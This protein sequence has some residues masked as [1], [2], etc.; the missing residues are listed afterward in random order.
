MRNRLPISLIAIFICLFGPDTF[1]AEG[2]TSGQFVLSPTGGAQYTIPIWAPPGPRGMQPNISLVYDSQAGIGPLGI[3]WSMSGLG[4]ITRCNLTV[5]QDTTPASVALVT[6]DG[7]CINGSRLRL[8]SG[9]YGTAGSVYQTEIAD[10]SQITAVGTAG[11]GPASFTVQAR[12]GLTYY[13]G[14]TD[15]NGNGVN[16]EVL[17][18][19]SST[20]LTWLLSKVVDRAGN[21]YVINYTALTGTAV[22]NDILWTPVSAGASTYT[23]KMLFNYTTNVPQSSINE[24]VAGT[25]VSNTD[26]LSSIEIFVGSTVVKDYFL[27]YQASPLTGREELISVKECAD[28]GGASCLLPTSISYQ[29]GAPGISTTPNSALSSSGGQLTTRYDLNGDGYPDLVYAGTTTMYVAFG[30]ATGYST[31]VN[32]G[33]PIANVLI[34]RLTE[35]SQDGILA[36]NAGTWWSYTWNGSSFVGT[37]T[38][39]AYDTASTGYQLADINGDGL[40]DLV[41]LNTV[42]SSFTKQYTETLYTQLN[43]SSGSTVSFGSTKYVSYS[44]IVSVSAQLLT[45]DMQYGKL[46]RYDFNGDGRDDLVLKTITG[47]SPNYVLKTYELLSSGTTFTASLIASAANGSYSPV[48]FTNWNDDKCTDFVSSNVLYVSGCNGTA[49]LSYALTGTILVA[50]DWDGDGRTDIL[51]QNGTTI[52]VYLSKAT[53]TPTMTTTTFPYNSSCQYVWMDANADGLDDLGCQNGAVTY[54]LHNGTSDLATEFADGYGNSASPTY[55]PISESNYTAYPSSSLQP[56]FPDIVYIGPLYVVSEVV[57]SDPS[58]AGNTYNQTF[59]YYAAWTNVQGRGF[60]GFQTIYT[61]DTRNAGPPSISRYQYFEQ[62]FPWTWMKYTDLITTPVFYPTYTVGTPNTLAQATLSTTTN[63][64]RFFPYFTN[65]TTTQKEVGGSENGDAITTTSTNYTYDAYGN[66]LTVD[67]TVTDNDPNSP[68]TGKTWTTNTTNT[69]DISVNQ[70]TDLAAWC[71][72]MLDET[73]VAYSSTLSGSTSVTRTKTFTPDTPANCRI[74][75]IITEPSGAYKVTESLVYDNSSG[76]TAFGNLISDTVAG[77]TT[78]PGNTVPSSPASRLT[79]LNW[80]TTGQFLNTLTDPSGATTTWTYS[81]NQALTFGVPDTKVDANALTTKYY[82]DAFGRKNRQIRPDGTSTTWTW[83]ACTSN[84]GNSVYQVAQT[85]YQTNGTTAIR[86]DTTS[87]D[88]VDRVTQTTGPTVTGAT[89]TVQTLYNSLGLV[90]EQSMPFLTGGTAYQQSFGYDVLNRLIE[91]ERPISASGGQ[92]YC[93][94]ASPPGSGCQGTSYT[95]AGRKLTITDPL[96]NTKTTVTDVNGWLRQTTDALGFYVTKAYD[97]AGSLVG[98]TDSVGN[99]LLKNV[100]VVYGIKPFVTAATDA[101]RGAWIYTVDSLGERL[102]W[103]DAKGQSFSMT[104]DALSRPLTRAEPDLYTQWTWGSTPASFNVG[105]LIAECTGSAGACSSSTG[106][107]ETRTF[108]SYGRPYQQSITQGGNPGFDPGGVFLITREYSTQDG[109][110]STLIYPTSTSSTALTLQYTYQYGLLNSVVDSTDTTAICGTTCTLWTASAM[111][112][113]GQ[114][115]Q[116]TLGNG[117]V[118]NRTYDPVTSWLTAAT[119]G[120]G[121]GAALLNQSYLQD[122][123]GNVTQRENNNTPGLYENFYYDGDN[124]LCDVVLNGTATRC[125]T[126]SMIYDGGNAGPG[127]ITTQTGVGTYAYPAAG[128]P[129]PH[130]VTSLTGTFNG[131]VNPIFSYDA[132][133]NMTSR[134]GSTVSWFSNNYPATISASDATGSEEV[135]FTYGPDRQRWKQTYTL[136]GATETT[137]YIGGL[138]DLVFNGITNFRHYIYAGSEPVAVYIRTNSIPT[139][140]NYMLEDHQGGVSAITSSVG[141]T[142]VNESFSS[143]GT[144]RNPNTWSGAPATADLNTIAGLSRQGYTF[145]TWLGQSMGLNH[146]NGR[147]QDAILGRFLSSDPHIP[148]P[149]NAQS[150]NRYSYVNNN[151]LTFTDPTGFYCGGPLAV[152]GLGLGDD[153][154]G[155]LGDDPDQLPEVQVNAPCL[156]PEVYNIPSPQISTPPPLMTGAVPR[157]PKITQQ[158]A[159]SAQ[160]N[161][162]L[163]PPLDTS[164]NRPYDPSDPSTHLYSVATPAGFLSADQQQQLLDLWRNGPNAAPG[165]AP[166][167]PDNTNVLLA[168]LPGTPNT[169]W[170]YLTPVSSGLGWV[171]VTQPGHYFYSGTVTNTVQTLGPVTYLSTVGTGDTSR[172]LQNDVFGSAFFQASQ[173]EAIAALYGA[174][175]VRIG[176]AGGC[177]GNH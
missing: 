28:S 35:G 71:L 21:N 58:S 98:V 93:N 129:Q 7:Y 50:L 47:T 74:T 25:L 103:T 160:S 123:N 118:I 111:N 119:A 44:T 97:S 157:F 34:G 52:G 177:N 5:A 33:I 171:N 135:Q 126:P 106:Y 130:A 141:G 49:A 46:R 36:N 108:D 158:S 91:S 166:N 109:R 75:A 76:G 155:D 68:Y 146:M 56:T 31:P 169:N 140:M 125:T 73:Q 144:R 164:S 61:Y 116:E 117:V 162:C 23:Y 165:I 59:H 41:D 152:P 99:S 43:T 89:A 110:L 72:N 8:T 83:S 149:T 100:A 113:F 137:Y 80:G 88:P 10:F 22:P 85:A 174:P 9:T 53:G 143:F 128:Q 153:L 163:A 64:E 4:A 127:N 161:P 176:S 150:Y 95:Y 132:N 57:F 96:G 69:T 2:R 82:Y 62:Q 17:A 145:Q 138:I 48:F 112:G 168:N 38:G 18:N 13:Y 26:L 78:A 65:V 29:G 151:P 122:E 45:P 60:E 94:P 30:S 54:Y 172:W 15:T 167:T 6:G 70:S 156:P 107:S 16:S 105:Q 142:D 51:V 19:G 3:G 114:V 1:A 90:V 27:G 42:Y 86:T 12:N 92:T 120:V 40:A 102:G 63:Q 159:P 154:D 175:R 81:S 66:A 147:V 133:G 134:A 32:T 14:L 79:T 67:T 148:D 101:D 139:T 121:G 37:S 24:Y 173:A 115:T 136:A 39:I 104:Y 55:V 20:A 170:I 84:C 131:I 124:R 77:N 11:N 87:Y